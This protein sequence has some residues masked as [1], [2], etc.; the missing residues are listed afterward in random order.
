[1]SIDVIV[2]GGTNQSSLH[3]I[4]PVRHVVCVCR[5]VSLVTHLTRVAMRLGRLALGNRKTY[6]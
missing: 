3:G 1:M 6:Y 2:Y 4:R 5:M